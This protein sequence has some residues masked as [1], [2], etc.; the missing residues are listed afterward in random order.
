[1]WRLVAAPAFGVFAA[2][3]RWHLGVGFADAKLD[4]TA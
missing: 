4:F 2:Q 3:K 1:L